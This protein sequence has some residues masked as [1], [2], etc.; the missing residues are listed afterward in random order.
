MVEISQIERWLTPRGRIIFR[1]WVK[2]NGFD[3]VVPR[4]RLV[5]EFIQRE[6]N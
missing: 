5:S 6:N 2:A 4:D 1:R 3:L